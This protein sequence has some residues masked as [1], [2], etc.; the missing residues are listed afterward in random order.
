MRCNA[1]EKTDLSG[2]VVQA[3]GKKGPH[4]LWHCAGM[5]EDAMLASQA[6][7]KLRSVYAPKAAGA[8][9][10]HGLAAKLHAVGPQ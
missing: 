3:L 6:A 4:G 7:E 5:L 8:R 9:S 10:L 1:A 2:T